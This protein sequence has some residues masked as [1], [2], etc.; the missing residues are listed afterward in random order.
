LTQVLDRR[1]I[2]FIILV[3]VAALSWWWP[4]ERGRPVRGAVPAG[5]EE[6]D[7]SFTGFVA[8]QMNPHGDLED[9]LS[10]ERVVHYPDREAAVLT[11]P[12]LDFY[13]NAR[14]T[15]G[16][17][18]RSGVVNEKDRS[19]WLSGEVRVAYAGEASEQGFDLYTEELRVWP[20]ER[21]AETDK[22]VR[23]VQQSGVIDSV[24]LRA[25]LGSRRLFL[26][27]QV[28]ATYGP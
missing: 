20:G 5:R 24:G 12:R 18:A 1:A 2:V 8:S 14:R 27:S 19:V 26:L 3:V 7:Y 25:D 21:R 22:P 6:A 11:G 15:W 9:T 10:A 17:I 4:Q 13:E 16:I 23:I 28:R